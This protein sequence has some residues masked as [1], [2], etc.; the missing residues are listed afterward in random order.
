MIL[1]GRGAHRFGDYE[2]GE[3]I[4]HVDGVTLEQA[5]I[6]RPRVVWTEHLESAFRRQ[7]APPMA[8]G[9]DLRRPHHLSLVRT[10]VVQTGWRMRRIDCR[11]QCRRPTRTP[12]Y[13]GDTVKGVVAEGAG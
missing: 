13:A 3:I 9:A 11:N 12:A 6:C 1:S 10:L 2:V 5:S 8:S 7:C 4:D